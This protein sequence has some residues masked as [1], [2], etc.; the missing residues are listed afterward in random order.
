[1]IIYREQYGHL[2]EGIKS[3]FPSSEDKKLIIFVSAAE[4]DSVCAL[5]LLT[6]ST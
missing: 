4:C 5:R 3:D 6:V 1:M 2:Y